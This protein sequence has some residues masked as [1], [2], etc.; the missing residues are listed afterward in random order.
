MAAIANVHDQDNS[1]ELDLG[2]IGPVVTEELW[3][4][5]SFKST[6]YTCGHALMALNGQ[7]TMMLHIPRARWFPFTWCGTPIWPWWANGHNVA[8]VQAKMFPMS[9]I[10][11]QSAQWLLNSS[12]C[13]NPGALAM[14]M[15]LP[16]LVWW[17]NNQNIAHLQA[18][19]FQWTWFGVNR[20]S[21]CWVFCKFGLNGEMNGQLADGQRQ[22][23]S[24]QCFFLRRQVT[25]SFDS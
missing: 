20:P 24:P 3:H 9:L 14:D 5:Q 1:S 17:A 2:W 8:H 23:H 7:M 10:W 11:G 4:P 6:Y 18:K 13:K 21:A 22:F 12:I 25:I 19:A 15:G 16:I